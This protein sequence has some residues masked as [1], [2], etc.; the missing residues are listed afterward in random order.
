[1]NINKDYRGVIQTERYV[2]YQ[3]TNTKKAYFSLDTELT[4]E[5]SLKRHSK[6]INLSLSYTLQ[7]IGLLYE[8]KREADDKNLS[9]EERAKLRESLAYPIMVTFEK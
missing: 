4:L 7:Q 2:V 5:E 9:Y 8:V 6:A 1:M 3:I